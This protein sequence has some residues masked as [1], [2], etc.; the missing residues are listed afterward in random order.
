MSLMRTTHSL[1]MVR[2]RKLTERN[3]LDD[4]QSFEDDKLLLVFN[5]VTESSS[6][7]RVSV[8]RVWRQAEVW[9]LFLGALLQQVPSSTETRRIS[10]L[11]SEAEEERGCCW[12]CTVLNSHL[13]VSSP[14]TGENV[15]ELQEDLDRLLR[16][17]SKAEGVWLG[18]ST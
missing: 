7:S 18:L 2:E 1:R 3:P 15:V 5:Q 10:R 12:F 13:R 17:G 14:T 16:R 8:E 9:L 11:V 6:R 4:K